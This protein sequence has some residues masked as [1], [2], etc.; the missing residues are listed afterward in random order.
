VTET[1]TI[2]ASTYDAA[3]R[4]K[5]RNFTGNVVT[6]YNYSPARGWVESINTVKGPT[7]HQN[8]VYTYYPDGMIQTV[9]SPKSME[10]WSYAYDDLNRLLSATNVDTP[11]LTQTFTYNEI[12]N[13]T[14]NSQIGTYTYPTPGTARPHAVS[15]A[16][17]RSYQYNVVGQMTSRNGTVTQWT[18]DGKPSSVGNVGFTY[19]G[20]GVRLKK[21]SGGQTTRYIGGDYEIA[22]DGTVT[23]YLRGGK[24][25]GATFFIHHR[26]HLGSIQAVTDSL[27]NEVRR[28]KHKPF[29]DQH[30]V[31]GSHIESKGWIGEREEETEL[32]YLNARYYDP[33]I[34]RFTSADPL[35]GRGQRL[36]RYSYSVNSP[37]SF[38]DPS[39]LT[40]ICHIQV[41]WES[42]NTLGNK[43]DGINPVMIEVCTPHS[44][45][46]PQ[47]EGRHPD[48]HRPRDR[49]RRPETGCGPMGRGP[50]KPDPPTTPPPIPPPKPPDEP[51]DDED[52]D[53]DQNSDESQE[54][55]VES[56]G[57]GGGGGGWAPTGGFVP[58]PCESFGQRFSENFWATNSVVPGLV[59][60][61]GAGLF[62]AGR[63]GAATGRVTLIQ[64]AELY[65]AGSA[66][67]TIASGNAAW[68]GQGAAT[69]ASTFLRVGAAWEL[70][71][72]AG[73]A[74]EAG[75]HWATCR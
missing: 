75:F 31:S 34:G 4:L 43:G 29:G 24:K 41:G 22:P 50:C 60:P 10:S 53:A 42:V 46:Y 25:V 74:L 5:T 11:S 55:D 1:G 48:P 17:P 49:E 71:I 73:S 9:T 68:L 66:N 45:P 38:S 44:S 56:G 2:T 6:T 57:G 14:S 15:T 67:G 27:G 61:T 3:G 16:G 58:A 59:A 37:I 26:D 19:D 64:G 12:G 18:G 70:G 7:V 28:Q 21:V 23:K 62:F 30:F 65:V 69:S 40:H 13:I 47:G 32:L 72:G 54:S 63:V 36:N 33:E 20:V 39:G 52:G 35:V 8:L 51:D